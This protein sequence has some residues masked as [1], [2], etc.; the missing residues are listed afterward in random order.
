MPHPEL[1]VE[2]RDGVAYLVTG[3][4]LQDDIRLEPGWLVIAA[5]AQALLKAAD[6]E[7]MPPELAGPGRLVLRS[8]RDP[9]RGALLDYDLTS[10][11]I[12]AA[13]VTATNLTW[14]N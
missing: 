5:G 14:R 9:M 13:D 8:R 11:F 4:M 7:E 3:S 6:F 10:G 1:R 2:L 12:R